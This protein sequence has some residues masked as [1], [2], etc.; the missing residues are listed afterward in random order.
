MSRC[1]RIPS[2]RSNASSSYLLV[3]TLNCEDLWGP[4]GT[5]HRPWLH[6]L[7]CKS[8]HPVHPPPVS[9]LTYCIPLSSP[10]DTFSWAWTSSHLVTSWCIHIHLDY[11]FITIISY[12]LWSINYLW[13]YYHI[14]LIYVPHFHYTF[15]ISEVVI[16]FYSTETLHIWNSSIELAS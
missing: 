9:R 14:Y 16:V 4:S 1:K 8:N 7:C 5:P 11:K 15:C 6:I 10:K 12:S 2:P 3:L 13:I